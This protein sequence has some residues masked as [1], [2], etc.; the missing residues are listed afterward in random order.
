MDPRLV[1]FP[2]RVQDLLELEFGL[3]QADFGQQLDLRRILEMWAWDLNRALKIEQGG[4]IRRVVIHINLENLLTIV[5]AFYTAYRL[6]NARISLGKGIQLTR[7][8]E[9]LTLE[10]VQI[11]EL[12]SE[13]AIGEVAELSVSFADVPLEGASPADIGDEVLISP[14]VVLDD[15]PSLSF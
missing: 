12:S 14:Q 11:E 5:R 15:Q 2:A 13:Q 10:A 6:V 7:G 9:V 1:D 3:T 4:S 8:A